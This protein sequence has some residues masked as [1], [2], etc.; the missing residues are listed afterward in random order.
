MQ[1]T[2]EDLAVEAARFADES[3]E[4][5]IETLADFVYKERA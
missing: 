5:A 3:P 4:P 1:Q 2:A